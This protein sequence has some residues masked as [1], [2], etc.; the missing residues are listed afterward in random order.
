[1]ISKYYSIKYNYVDLITQSWNQI[2]SWVFEASEAIIG[3]RGF[4]NSFVS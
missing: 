3:S 2:H 1:M 4:E